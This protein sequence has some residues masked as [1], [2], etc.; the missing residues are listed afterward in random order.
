MPSLVVPSFAVITK[1]R[2]WTSETMSSDR[3]SV[4]FTGRPSS[5]AAL[6]ATMYSTYTA[7]FGPKPPPTHGQRTRS[8]SG[9][10]PSTG[11]SAPCAAC[12]AWC[13]T[14]Q[15]TPP[16][17]SPGTARITLHSIGTPARR[18]LT[19]VTSA[20]A[21]A[22]SSAS[23]SSPN[24]V[25]KQMFEPCSGNSSGALGSSAAAAVVTAGSASTSTITDSAAS[26]AC[27]RVSATTAATMSPT[28]RTRSLAKI[29]RLTSAGII[30]KPW[31]GASPR[32]LP[33]AAEYTATTPGID[34]AS[35]VST[36]VMVPWATAE[37]TNT[38]WAVPSCSRSSTYL[39]AP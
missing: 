17:G 21:S 28:K 29:G 26:T 39:P 37:R 8:C 2:P 33:S 27:V 38:T 19:I 25:P 7:A 18:W 32:S 5:I 31:N 24:V 23:T 35:L 15:V 12:G 36:E 20:T 13:D 4:H 14:Q 10:S 3:V 34:S 16:S 22:P 9:S 6:A 11:A 1:S 30:G